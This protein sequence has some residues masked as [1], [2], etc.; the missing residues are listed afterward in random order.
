MDY[1]KITNKSSSQYKIIQTLDKSS[2]GLLRDKEGYIAVALGS[3]YGDIGDKF[4]V[5][6]S[7]GKEVKVIKADEKSDKDTINGCFHKSD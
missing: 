5:K 6:L 2:D 7:T 4:I 3:K 1:K